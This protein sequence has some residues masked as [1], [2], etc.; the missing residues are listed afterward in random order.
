MRQQPSITRCARSI[1]KRVVISSLIGKRNGWNILV[2]DFGSRSLNVHVNVY[3][4]N[5][6]MAIGHVSQTSQQGNWLS[7][8]SFPFKAICLEC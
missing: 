7:V 1:L 5:E 8:T 2:A 3:L 4:K 6:S